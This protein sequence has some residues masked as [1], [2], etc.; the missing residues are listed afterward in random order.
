MGTESSDKIKVYI[1]DD[2]QMFVA[3]LFSIFEGDNQIDMVGSNMQGKLALE[4]LSQ[5][6]IDIILLDIN[7]PG[8]DGI[9]LNQFIQQQLHGTKV[10]ALT[11]HREAVFIQKMIKG[12]AK[13]YVLKNSGKDQLKEAILTVAAGGTWF[14]D[15]VKEALMQD[16]MP[17]SS[18]TASD[19]YAPY[20]PKLSRRE[21][22]VL[23]LITQEFTTSEIAKKLFISQNT[24][25][26]HRK[27]LLQ[28]LDVRNTAG[29]VRLAVEKGLID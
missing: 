6:D 24:V 13:G 1:I 23:L 12:G 2:H 29:L 4:E 22:E 16:L 14:G 17:G 9:R 10:I 5:L 26:T 15:D 25:E 19:K 21:K 3:G 28:K 8:I 27:N 7:L 20:I 11:M 18:D